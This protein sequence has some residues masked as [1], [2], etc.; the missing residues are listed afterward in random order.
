MELDQMS[1]RP[2]LTNDE[3]V[4]ER[5]NPRKKGVQQEAGRKV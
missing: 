5:L 2:S 1:Y 3:Q 4:L